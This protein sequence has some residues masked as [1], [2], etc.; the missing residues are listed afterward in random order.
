MFTDDYNLFVALFLNKLT[1][2]KKYLVVKNNLAIENERLTCCSEKLRTYISPYTSPIVSELRKNGFQLLGTT[3]MDEFAC[4]CY[5]TNTFYKKPLSPIGNFSIGGSSG[6]SGAAVARLKEYSVLGLGSTTGGSIALPALFNSVFGFVPSKNKISRVGL[7]DYS[8][9]LDRI[10]F[11]FLKQKISEEVHSLLYPL[12]T[13]TPSTFA[14]FYPPSLDEVLKNLFLEFLNK[15]FPKA[16]FVNLEEEL[17]L[18]EKIYPKIA[19]PELYS[20]LK[21][22]E[23]NHFRNCVEGEEKMKIVITQRIEKGK[24]FILNGEYP[25]AINLYRTLQHTLLKKL[26]GIGYL[27][28]PVL[29]TIPQK[30]V[31]FSEQLSAF[32]NLAPFSTLYVPLSNLVSIQVSALTKDLEGSELLFFKKWMKK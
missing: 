6:G 27:F 2:S 5:S 7:V 30:D 13:K 14:F 9:T 23:K 12:Q 18:F 16:E 32:S 29:S 10:G 17:K 22:F 24:E 20:N 21:R 28:L 25:Q 8:N 1:K 15:N 3:C 26:E 11:L 4:G 19:Y 31:P